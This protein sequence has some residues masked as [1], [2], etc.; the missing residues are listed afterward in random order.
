[1]IPVIAFSAWSGT[2]K[3]T[4]IE[5]LI[6]ILKQKGLRVAAVKHDSHHFEIDQEGKDSWLFTQAGADITMLS[7]SEQTVYMEQRSL[8][9]EQT[10]AM[11]HDVDLILAEGY[12]QED[13]PKIGISRRSTGMGFRLPT[14]SYIALVSDELP[15]DL[16]DTGIPEFDLDD[17]EGLAAFILD[18]IG[19]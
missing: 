17:A 19:A 1:M 10:F 5:K 8:S 13:L 2:G 7:S 16:P 4:L 6:R 12:N 11:I 15:P 14:T 9:L 3:T 18:Y